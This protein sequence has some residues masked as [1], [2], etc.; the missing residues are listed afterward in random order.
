MK[1]EYLADGSPDCPLVRLFEFTPTEL[2]RLYSE[3]MSLASETTRSVAVHELPGVESIGGC[4]LT[5]LTDRRDKGMVRVAGPA[6]FECRVTPTSWDNVAGLVEP[7]LEP[8]F[9]HYQWLDHGF[10]G[11]TGL[12]LSPSGDW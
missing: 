4:R 7:F 8:S 3:I 11:D 5:F 6:E 12:L 1:I 2:Q 9:G 10:G